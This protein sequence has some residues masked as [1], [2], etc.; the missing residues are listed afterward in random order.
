MMDHGSEF[1]G[2]QPPELYPGSAAPGLKTQVLAATAGT[3]RGGGAE[4][5]F[6]LAPFGG[7]GRMMLTNA[8]TPGI[9]HTLLNA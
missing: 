3:G 9:E 1:S 6:A 8:P 2:R 5:S 7:K 4:L